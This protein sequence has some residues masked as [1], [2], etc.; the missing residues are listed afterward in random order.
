[1]PA[2]ALTIEDRRFSKFNATEQSSGRID[3]S[4]EYTVTIKNGGFLP[5]PSV[6]FNVGS[7]KIPDTDV[8]LISQK[9]SNVGTIGPG[10]SKDM[11]LEFTLNGPSSDLRSVTYTACGGEAPELNIQEQAAGILLAIGVDSTVQVSSPSPSCTFP[12]QPT[13]GPEPPES[14]EPPEEDPQ[15]PE[16]PDPPQ[17]PEPPEQPP[18]EPE[19]PEEEP[20]EEDPDPEP[21]QDEPVDLIIDDMS[22]STDDGEVTITVTVSTEGLDSG[23]YDTRSV[24][25]QLVDDES[26]V[27]DSDSKTYS[28]VDNYDNSEFEFD[29]LTFEDRT[30]V[31]ADVNLTEPEQLYENDTITVEATEDTGG[32]GGNGGTEPFSWEIVDAEG[33]EDQADVTVSTTGVGNR[34]DATADIRLV[35]ANTNEELAGDQQS[36]IGGFDNYTFEFRNIGLQ[37]GQSVDA[38]VDANILQPEAAYDSAEV[39]IVGPVVGGLELDSPIP[40]MDEAADEQTNNWG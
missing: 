10:S 14:P 26:N 27:L 3:I 2:N 11:T 13:P 25:V 39:Q 6:S 9:S 29:R 20:P 4:G 1:M 17:Q 28:Y 15:P 34:E 18:E 21:P 38:R 19:P 16:E 30:N 23:N 24:D 35:D 12:Q 5:V 36:R 33:G 40:S 37:T 32:G 8:E 31:R 7:M 22:S